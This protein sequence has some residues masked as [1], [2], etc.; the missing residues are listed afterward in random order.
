[1]QHASCRGGFGGGHPTKTFGLFRCL[2]GSCQMFSDPGRRNHL[3]ANLNF[4]L[5]DTGEPCQCLRHL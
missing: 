1:M 2:T 4:G 5:V 3:D